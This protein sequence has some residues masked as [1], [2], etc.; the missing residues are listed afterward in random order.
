MKKQSGVEPTIKIKTLF[1]TVLIVF[2]VFGLIET[3][4]EINKYKQRKKNQLWAV[5][6]QIDTR[7]K[8][9]KK[10]WTSSSFVDGVINYSLEIIKIAYNS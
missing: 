9:Q 4:K 5:S 3:G 10:E 1:K 6:Q 7:I 8:K 2:I